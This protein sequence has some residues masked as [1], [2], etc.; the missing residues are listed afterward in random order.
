MALDVEQKKIGDV[1]CV[2]LAGR[3]VDVDVKKL[4]K[5]LDSLY[6]KSAPRVVLDVTNTDFVD[7]HGLGTIVYYHTLLQKESRE[8][9]ILNANPNPNSYLNRLFE[10]T[11]L[12]K[13]LKIVTDE[14][15][16]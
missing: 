8:L 7:S 3:A 2:A 10:L 12:N 16:V 5:G 11:H 14:K 13:V 1:P 9:L 6:K 4:V 15:S